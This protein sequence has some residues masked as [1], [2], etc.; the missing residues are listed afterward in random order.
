MVKLFL[1]HLTKQHI[2]HWVKF[3]YLSWQSFFPSQFF[4]RS[5]ICV[6]V[7]CL[8]VGVLTLSPFRFIS[9]IGL[10]KPEPDGLHSDSDSLYITTV[11][12]PDRFLVESGCHCTTTIG[13]LNS[14]PLFQN[15]C[16]Q[17]VDQTVTTAN[18]TKIK[19]SSF[20]HLK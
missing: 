2:F 11:W 9:K 12:L 3:L 20:I 4:K 14:E 1:G 8:C 10:A 17:N 6:C 19:S 5:F 13:Q 18:P 15:R 7:F 16:F